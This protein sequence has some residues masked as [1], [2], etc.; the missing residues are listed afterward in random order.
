MNPTATA[1]PALM[2][3]PDEPEWTIENT[4]LS[5]FNPKDLEV[6]MYFKPSGEKK[7]N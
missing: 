3:G 1:A 7:R 5:P 4:K 6:R 2:K